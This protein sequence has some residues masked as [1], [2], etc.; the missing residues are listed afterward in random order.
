MGPRGLALVAVFIGS[1]LTPAL[2]AE[3]IETR[4]GVR[5]PFLYGPGNNAFA[6][7][8]LLSGGNGRIGLKADSNDANSRNFLVRTRGLFR[9]SGLNA[10]TVDAPTDHRTAEGMSGAFRISADHARDLDAVAA[11]LKAK[12]D[13]PVFLVGTSMGTISAANAAAR[14]KE[15]IY[16]GVVLT[17]SVTGT[18]RKIGRAHV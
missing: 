13:M 15:G 5:Q 3:F 4:P 16:A 7:V 14:Q 6:S 11:F 2:A 9:A 1:L 10:A 18:S 12:Y 17:S 8:I